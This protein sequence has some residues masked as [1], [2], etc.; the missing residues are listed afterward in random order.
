MIEF[1]NGNHCSEYG[2]V[3]INSGPREVYRHVL[4]NF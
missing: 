4:E 3:S 2:L 1:L